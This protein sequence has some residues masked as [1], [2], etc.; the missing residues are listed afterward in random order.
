MRRLTTQEIIQLAARFRV[1]EAKVRACIEG[2]R[3][4]KRVSSP[5]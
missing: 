5:A 1:S 4:A 3:T 2:F